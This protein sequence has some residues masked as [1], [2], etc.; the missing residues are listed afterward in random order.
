MAILP[1]SKASPL[2]TFPLGLPLLSA[3][4]QDPLG[5][6]T[7]FQQEFGDVAK[8]NILFRRIYY[9]YAP[10]VV[11]K[12]LVEH[13]ADFTRERRQLDVFASVQGNNVLTTEGQ[14]WERQRRI[15][16]PGFSPKRITGYMALM[17]DAIKDCVGEELP[18]NKGSSAVV[19]VDFLTTRMTMDVILRAL[20][21]YKTTREEAARIS[22][23]IRALS[24]QGMRELFWV[25]IPPSWFPYPGRSHKNAHKKT[26]HDLITAQIDARKVDENQQD[27]SHDACG[28]R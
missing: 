9:F 19:D 4:Q 13:H 11:R 18:T 26:I 1:S 22:I 21:S 16:T 28:A 25:F 23:A 5:L 3:I 15:L 12:I 8:L 14:D 6:A 20:F 17:E 27:S 7:R 24:K 2:K 10:D